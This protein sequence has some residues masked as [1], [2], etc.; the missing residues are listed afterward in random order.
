MSQKNRDN[1][2]MFVPNPSTPTIGAPDLHRNVRAGFIARGTS[3]HAWCR[4]NQICRPSADKAL[5]GV[6]TGPGAR[7]LI[8]RLVTAAGAG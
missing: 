3:L 4:E 6:W 1:C 7:K 2:D 5:K 8:A